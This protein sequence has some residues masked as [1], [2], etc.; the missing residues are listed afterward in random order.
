MLVMYYRY[1]DRDD[2][3]D[4][5]YILGFY[6]ELN[7]IHL[8]ELPNKCHPNSFPPSLVRF[9]LMMLPHEVNARES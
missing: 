8:H 1:I 7:K 6:L 2:D 5:D 9:S 3:G 4:N